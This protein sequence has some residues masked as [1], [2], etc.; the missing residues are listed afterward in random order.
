MPQNLSCSQ[1]Q[2]LL[3]F[4]TRA[5]WDVVFGLN[6]VEP[7]AEGDAQNFNLDMLQ[8]LASYAKKR[9]DSG[10]PRFVWVCR[11]K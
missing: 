8:S 3:D 11:E 6:S 2:G 4:A 5:G 7:L 1:F 10:K 9:A